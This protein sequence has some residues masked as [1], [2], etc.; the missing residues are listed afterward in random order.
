MTHILIN[1]VRKTRV[2]SAKE[3][4]ENPFVLAGENGGNSESKAVNIRN[5]LI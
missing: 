1:D 3:I 4:T 2:L 5:V